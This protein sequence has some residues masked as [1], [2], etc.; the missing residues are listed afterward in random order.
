MS[1]EQS[2]VAIKREMKCGKSELGLLGIQCRIAVSVSLSVRQAPACSISS[3]VPD[4][5]LPY[6][7]ANGSQW[8]D[9]PQR[10]LSTSLH[11]A[12]G[13]GTSRLLLSIRYHYQGKKKFAS[14]ELCTF[15][16][17]VINGLVDR[18]YCLTC[19]KRNRNRRIENSAS[20]T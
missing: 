12:R 1:Q 15:L 10:F 8:V 3:R 19:V 4:D 5:V 20:G 17:R 7:T 2:S 11:K 14:C 18:L 13:F 9:V 16:V 6:L